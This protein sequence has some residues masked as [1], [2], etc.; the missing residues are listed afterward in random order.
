[1][2]DP[3]QR[4]S[5][6]LVDWGALAFSSP[7]IISSPAGGATTDGEVPSSCAQ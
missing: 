2:A 6:T 4:Q 5:M 1:V 7:A 3:A